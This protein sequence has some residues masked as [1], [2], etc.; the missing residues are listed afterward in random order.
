MLESLEVW[1]DG[2]QSQCPELPVG[3]AGHGVRVRIISGLCA[4]LSRVFIM[5]RADLGLVRAAELAARL[6]G[7]E[8]S[9]AWLEAIR[10][11]GNGESLGLAMPSASDLLMWSSLRS[12]LDIDDSSNGL[13]VILSFADLA[14]I[15]RL[16]DLIVLYYRESGASNPQCLRHAGLAV[17]L[18]DL[19]QKAPRLLLER[20]FELMD[21]AE[22]F[23]DAFAGGAGGA[24]AWFSIRQIAGATALAALQLYQ[25]Q[26]RY[27]RLYGA[28]VQV[29][30]ASFGQDLPPVERLAEGWA[31]HALD[32]R[33]GFLDCFLEYSAAASETDEGLCFWQSALIGACLEVS[34]GEGAEGAF[35]DL[36]KLVGERAWAGKDCIQGPQVRRR[37]RT[38][39]ER[40]FE[41]FGRLEPLPL[42]RFAIAHLDALIMTSIGQM[43]ESIQPGF[44]SELAAAFQCSLLA[45]LQRIPPPELPALAERVGEALQAIER[46]RSGGAGFAVVLGQRVLERMAEGGLYHRAPAL[47]ILVQL[48]RLLA[49]GG[50]R[51][52]RGDSVTMELAWTLK[53]LILSWADAPEPEPW[54]PPPLEGLGLNPIRLALAR[55]LGFPRCVY[56]GHLIDWEP[57]GDD[58]RLVASEKPPVGVDN[59]TAV[60]VIFQEGRALALG[61]LG[62]WREIYSTGRPIL[63][64][65]IR[66]MLVRDGQDV[67][68]ALNGLMGIAADGNPRLNAA[69]GT[70]SLFMIEVLRCGLPPTRLGQT[71]PEVR[72][73]L[74]DLNPESRILDNCFV[75][76]LARGILCARRPGL[77]ICQPFIGRLGRLGGLVQLLLGEVPDWAALSDNSL[78]TRLDL[79]LFAL[80]LVQA[81]DTNPTLPARGGRLL[82]DAQDLNAFTLPAEPALQARLSAFFSSDPQY[83]A[84]FARARRLAGMDRLEGWPL[85][86]INRVSNTDSR[87][88]AFLTNETD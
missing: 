24:D 77:T 46:R 3:L 81:R 76:F 7:P 51:G 28:A 49:A 88:A 16:S 67:D 83:P 58:H 82:V 29:G 39:F 55:S 47:A 60:P 1:L 20:P 33:D 23:P 74:L 64:D 50:I 68:D 22:T 21:L 35:R 70:D 44:R 32:L 42:M 13:G 52:P 14:C 34:R 84:A 41:H 48:E 30:R 8:W 26:A 80:H 45:V 11:A 19:L 10:I 57:N 86:D 25:G 63:Q 65:Q 17:R 56:L 61:A 15:R 12:Q 62:L 53:R 2:E 18:Q 75:L 40:L 27:L 66:V 71:P 85:E 59:E 78:R 72:A 37:V 36:V 9:C 54:L 4:R 79:C 31:V 5:E 73:T 38:L 87:L 43:M 6:N 69:V